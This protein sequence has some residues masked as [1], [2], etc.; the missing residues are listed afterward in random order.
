MA[1]WVAV[2]GVDL[3]STWEIVRGSDVRLLAVAVLVIAVQTT[4]RSG[5]WRL[6]LP[7]SA[8]RRPHLTRVIPVLLIGYLGNAVLPARLGEA[9]RAAVLARRE[10]LSTAETLGSVL[11]ERIVDTMALAAFALTVAFAVGLGERFATIGL[12]A[13]AV[14]IA[15]VLALTAAPRLVGK[16]KIPVLARV[17]DAALAILRGAQVRDRPM[18]IAAA[19]GLSLLAW[20]LDAAIYLLAARAIGIDLPVH[21]AVV[22]SAVAALSTAVPSAPGFVGTFELAISTIAQAFGV[23]AAT[24]LALAIVVHA[25]ALI[26]TSL[27]GVVAAIVVGRDGSL[28]GLTDTIP[29]DRRPVTQL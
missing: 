8:A 22:I 4:L 27:A 2:Q 25:V 1:A 3:N 6:V 14:G 26:P 5:R 21:A 23:E 15:A 18:T 12:L 10:R 20:I 11:I 19:A 29:T 24:A 16:V 7:V 17:R 9:L 13:I 28:A